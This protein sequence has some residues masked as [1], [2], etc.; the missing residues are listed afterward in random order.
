M[1]GKAVLLM[2]PDGDTPNA[3]DFDAGDDFRSFEEAIRSAHERVAPN[4]SLVP[5]IRFG[6]AIMDPAQV[7]ATNTPPAPP[8]SAGSSSISER[9]DEDLENTFPASDPP[10]RTAP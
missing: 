4:D 6:G 7:M 9:L 5:W 1:D 10:A 3:A 2:M 8:R